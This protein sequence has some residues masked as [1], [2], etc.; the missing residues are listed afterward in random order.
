MENCFLP[1]ESHQ[2]QY[3]WITDISA[4]FVSDKSDILFK[5]FYIYHLIGTENLLTWQPM[6]LPDDV[7]GESD[8]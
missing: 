5:L 8:E 6:L 3:T 4:Y 7:I 2:F 1:C